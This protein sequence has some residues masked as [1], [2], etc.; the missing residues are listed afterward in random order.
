M[1]ISGNAAAFIILR[2]HK[3]SGKHAQVPALLA[4]ILFVG[5]S[6][7][8]V[9]HEGDGQGALWA[10]NVGEA[11]LSIELSSVLA[12]CL[13]VHSEA[14]RPGLGI[15]EEIFAV[16][17]MAGAEPFGKKSFYRRSF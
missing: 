16:R 2:G 15:S 11:D 10:G 13:Q 4:N 1:Q 8:Y 5:A 6:L 7:G 12:V 3:F 9:G 14:H 17:D